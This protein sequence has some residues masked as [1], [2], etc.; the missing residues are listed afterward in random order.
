MKLY[1]AT[2]KGWKYKV[3]AVLVVNSKGEVY[4]HQF[5]DK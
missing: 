5:D 4:E 1:Q 2:D 3:K